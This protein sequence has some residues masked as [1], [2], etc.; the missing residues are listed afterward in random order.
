MACSDIT[1]NEWARSEAFDF[2]QEMMVVG[3]GV[4]GSPEV[5]LILL[6][7][8]THLVFGVCN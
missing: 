8:G 1:S 5:N 3:Y 6:K 7:V 4:C 2:G